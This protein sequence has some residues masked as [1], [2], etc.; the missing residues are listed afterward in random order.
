MNADLQS[1][2]SQFLASTKDLRAQVL[3]DPN[4][5]YDWEGAVSEVL[6]G[7]VK[8]QNRF[9]D[10]AAVLEFLKEVPDTLAESFQREKFYTYALEKIAAQAPASAAYYAKELKT[11]APALRVMSS[12]QEKLQTEYFNTVQ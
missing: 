5:H 3:G 2:D 10:R 7:R 11:A 12:A 4:A 1:R 8:Q 9:A 6:M